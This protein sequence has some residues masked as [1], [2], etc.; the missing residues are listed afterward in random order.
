[1]KSV[2]NSSSSQKRPLLVF[3]RRRRAPEG[4]P[5]RVRDPNAQNQQM[6][7]RPDTCD[8]LGRFHLTP[9]STNDYLI[10]REVQKKG[11]SFTGING[12]GL[13]D[14]AITESEGRIFDRTIEHL[15]SSDAMIVRSRKRIIDAAKAL[16]DQ[17]VTPPGVDDP[18]VYRVRGG[19]VILP[20][21]ADWLAA[22]EKWR[23]AFVDHPDLDPSIVG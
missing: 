5:N 18:Q 3:A 20:V 4:N 7:Y 9:D 8:W 17:G 14:Q 6:Q 11:I 2:W 12:V 15:G 1:M 13:Q 22:T 19:G 21:D 23:Q 16:R 10:D